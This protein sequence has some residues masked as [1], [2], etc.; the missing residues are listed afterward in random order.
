MN[1]TS[2]PT[3]LSPSGPLTPRIAI[4]SDH[5][6]RS[7]L[8]SNSHSTGASGSMLSSALAKYGIQLSQCY[9]THVYKSYPP[10][11]EMRSLYDDPKTC[12]KPSSSLLESRNLLL[13]ELNNVRPNIFLLLGH[14]PLRTILN[15]SSL[16]SLRGSIFTYKSIKLMA[17]YHPRDIFKT[18]SD[19]PVFDMDIRRLASESLSPVH[20]PPR[21]DF[22]LQPSLKTVLEFLSLPVD[23]AAVDIETTGKHVRCVGIA[24][25]DSKAIV[26][27]FIKRNLGPQ[28]SSSIINLSPE[29][30][31]V[32]S[33]WSE[34]E[35]RIIL[36]ALDKF[37]RSSTK[38]VLQNYAFD[39][40]VLATEFGLTIPNLYLDTMIGWHL[41]YPELPKG[42][43]FLASILTN[44]P[45]YS[46]YTVS[47]DISTW[48]YCAYDC[49]ATF[50]ASTKIEKE[51][52][53]L[54]LWEYYTNFKLPETFALARMSS[55]G[56]YQ[57]TT[58]R[59]RLKIQ[60]ESELLTMGDQ[61]KL[62]CGQDF[63]PRSWL[64]KS[65]LFYKTL[66]LPIQ[67]KRKDGESRLTTDKNAVEKLIRISP[68]HEATLRLINDYSQKAT[69]LSTFLEVELGPDNRI[70]SSFNQSGTENGRLSSSKHIWN[71]GGN[72]QNI[73]KRG[74]G[75][76]FRRIFKGSDSKSLLIKCDLAQAQFWIVVWLAQI[77]RLIERYYSDPNFDI[78]RWVASLI[79]KKPE[80]SII[81]SERDIAKNGVYG[82]SFKM[83]AVRASEVYKL[84][85]AQAKWVLDEY[86]SKIPEIPQWWTS[87]ERTLTSTRK[88]V[89]PLGG[90]R[91]FMGRM[92]D[93]T[94]RQAY[95]CLPQK[96]E[97]EIVGRALC[98]ATETFDPNECFPILV[99]HD[100][101]VFE[102][103]NP[104][105]LM[106]YA[107]RIKSLMQYPIYFPNI[108][109]PLT[110]RAD[111]S[112]GPT[113]YSKSKIL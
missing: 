5:P 12:R 35:E 111:V 61:L 72:L 11:G 70:Y 9:Q 21:T 105:K 62:I 87:V 95:A 22:I 33:Y 43:D 67:Y 107:K 56:V 23:K 1:L 48:T 79:F 68:Q 54:N 83:H 20:T 98:L 112:Y 19:R 17:S 7:D 55:T 57:D 64:Q 84:P 37:L 100:E 108:K 77:H 74:P 16:Q 6:S 50:Q 109:L 63:N 97:S 59:A 40:V 73:P 102:L 76:A 90:S 32:T 31:T 24:T 66:G 96:I 82:G 2:I 42:L 10:N 34:D 60:T 92:D 44:I 13:N 14:E 52:R 69:L 46:N 71:P 18:Y 49:I 101:I 103:T 80:S 104:R 29:T 47:D 36:T 41:C 89:S 86:R 75:R 91:I 27:P 4:I 53:D 78:H 110:I 99:V 93:E 26:I 94:F 58:E 113:W 88:L 3:F 51:L 39:S 28:I 65:E 15:S 85:L 8:T 45:Y 106:H 81:T 30:T 38:F 25:S